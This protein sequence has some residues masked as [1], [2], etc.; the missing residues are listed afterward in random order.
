MGTENS[1]SLSA[2]VTG[3]MKKKLASLQSVR[4][5]VMASQSL[6]LSMN[7]KHSI[8][9]A[10]LRICA[11]TSAAVIGKKGDAG[12]PLHLTLNTAFSMKIS[13]GMLTNGKSVKAEVLTSISAIKTRNVTGMTENAG[14]LSEFITIL[15]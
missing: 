11:R 1:A 4:M 13:G 5:C 8:T 15:K 7:A 9:W 6:V 10:R 14:T 3:M 12:A 2:A